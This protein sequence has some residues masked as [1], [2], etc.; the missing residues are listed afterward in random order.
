MYG[1][2]AAFTSEMFA[3]ASRYTG[4]SLGYQL[5]TTLGGGFA[6]LIAASLV[7]GASAGHGLLRVALFA[8]GA[9]LLSAIVVAAATETSKRDLTAVS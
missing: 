2:L 1:P 7:A 9:C 5:S 8:A 4:A 6:P 3:T